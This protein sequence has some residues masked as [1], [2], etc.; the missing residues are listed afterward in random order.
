[1]HLSNASH[2]EIMRIIR[3]RR[4]S[5]E[6]AQAMRA[7]KIKEK[8]PAFSKLD[9]DFLEKASKLTDTNGPFDALIE[10]TKKK[11][12][13]LLEESGFP[14]NYLEIQYFCKDCQDTGRI[15]DRYCRCFYDLSYQLLYK[16][17]ALLQ[18]L[19]SEC[20][21]NFKL[22]YYS[23]TI[24]GDD[25][26]PR[27]QATEALRIGTEFAHN[28]AEKY[29]NLIIFGSTGTGKTFLANCI[30]AE[31][32]KQRRFVLFLS[33]T[34][35]FDILREYSYNKDDHNQNLYKNIFSCDLLI[36][37]DLGTESVTTFTQHSFF[38]VVNERYNKRRATII[39][40]N[41]TMNHIRDLYSERV[42]SRI[43]GYYTPIQLSGDDIRIQESL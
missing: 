25:S 36:I 24:K 20:F 21:D 43:L 23:D 22:D 18:T 2:D 6:R 29:D 26:S 40:T 37:D 31:L 5:A 9:E 13:A 28:F 3:A 27:Q 30:T 35:L 34:A 7:A 10:A 32:I 19:Q 39:T 17:S 1:M 16:D 42:C 11:K 15:D 14:A 4:T 8:L 38:Q 41:L 33:A 12:A